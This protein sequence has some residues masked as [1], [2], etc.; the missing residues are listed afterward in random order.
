MPGKSNVEF[1]GEIGERDKGE[2]EEAV[3][4]SIPRADGDQSE[5]R[6]KPD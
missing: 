6:A 2:Y 3:E 5:H 1:V 4:G